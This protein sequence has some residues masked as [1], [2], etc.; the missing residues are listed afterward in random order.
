[1]TTDDPMELIIAEGLT[2]AGIAFTHES[3]NKSQG[4]DFKLTQYGVLIECKQFPTDRTSAQIAL[5]PNVI[6]I[7]GREAAKCFAAMINSVRDPP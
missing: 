6:V 7:Q 4:L 3:D 1:M 2:R 5:Y